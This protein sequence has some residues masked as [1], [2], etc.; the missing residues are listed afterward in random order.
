MTYSSDAA[1]MGQLELYRSQYDPPES[2]KDFGREWTPFRGCHK[3]VM[4]W[5]AVT[6]WSR[7]DYKVALFLCED[8]VGLPIGW[9]V[10]AGLL[11][12]LA[13]AYKATGKMSLRF[14]GP[15]KGAKA[16][17]ET[18]YE[19]IIPRKIR[20]LASELGIHLKNQ[21]F[22]EDSEGRLLFARLTGFSSQSIE[23][24]E[25]KGVDVV[26]ACMLTHRGVWFPSSIHYLA[27]ECLIPANILRGEAKPEFWGIFKADLL[28]LRVAITAE[29]FLTALDTAC[30]VQYGNHPHHWLEGRSMEITIAN[31][32]EVFLFGGTRLQ[33]TSGDRL[34]V[35]FSPRDQTEYDLLAATDYLADGKLPLHLVVTKDFDWVSPETRRLAHEAIERGYLRILQIFETVDELDGEAMTRLDQ[36]A[37]LRAPLTGSNE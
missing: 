36:A 30:Q 26:H 29:R 25:S 3:D 37:S 19:P 24:L 1:R 18:G 27:R 10:R 33:L 31:D 13:N 32:G 34:L 16:N 4:L 21:R 11:T 28:D 17:P 23:A 14:Y 22:I 9:S 7:N 8:L 2:P 15:R 35:K 6:K 5:V 12:L 20:A